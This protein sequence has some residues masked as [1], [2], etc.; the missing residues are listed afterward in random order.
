MGDTWGAIGAI[1]SVVG[2][3]GGGVKYYKDNKKSL[4]ILEPRFRRVSADVFDKSYTEI[5]IFND[6]KIPIVIR[7][8]GVLKNNNTERKQLE[9]M[10]NFT[11]FTI[12]RRGNPGS[13]MP[14]ITNEN[15]YKTDDGITLDNR[16]F[17]SNNRCVI[18]LKSR[19][20]LQG[21]ETFYIRDIEGKEWSYKLAK[22]RNHIEQI[23]DAYPMLD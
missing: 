13:V 9:F 2:V 17:S 20:F 5:E 1:I 14:D 19:V 12:G 18:T 22:A 15:N 11:A 3:I 21:I 23:N 4:L 7:E 16:N 6:G 10:S 8:I